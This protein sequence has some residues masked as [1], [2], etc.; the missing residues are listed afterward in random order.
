MVQVVVGRMK[1]VEETD[2]PSPVTASTLEGDCSRSSRY[3]SQH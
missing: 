2:G 3:C 1:S